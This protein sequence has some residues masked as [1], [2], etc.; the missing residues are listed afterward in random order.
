MVSKRPGFDKA[1]QVRVAGILTRRLLLAAEL[2]GKG[3]MKNTPVEDGHAHAAWKSAFDQVPTLQ[4]KIAVPSGTSRDSQAIG[5]GKASAELTG[6]NQRITISNE[7]EFVRKIEYG[8]PITP[9]GPG[10]KKQP[11]VVKRRTVNDPSGPLY[12]PRLSEGRGVLVWKG[13]D[14]QLHRGF[15]FTEPAASQ[16]P[17][18]RAIE[19]A[20]ASLK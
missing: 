16:R 19:E 3:V 12:G 14:G 11:P 7:L 15:T 20:K 2:V 6:L 13:A 18:Q 8:L 10:G 9:I 5:A 17:V 1:L 4:G